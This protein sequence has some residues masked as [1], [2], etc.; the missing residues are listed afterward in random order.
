MILLMHF[1]VL[2]LSNQNLPEVLMAL[3]GRNGTERFSNKELWEF[4]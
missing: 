3:I 4:T 1:S 2:C